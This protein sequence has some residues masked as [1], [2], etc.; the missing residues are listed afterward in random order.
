MS[1]MSNEELA[2]A[3]LIAYELMGK[4]HESHIAYKVL[5]AHLSRL[6]DCQHNR[7]T[8]GNYY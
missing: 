6:L 5:Y 4:H 7:A 8:R 1:S 3:I 2:A